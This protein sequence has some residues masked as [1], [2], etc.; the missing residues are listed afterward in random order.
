[1][2]KLK[3]AQR[4]RS[5]KA[6]LVVLAEGFM[7]QKEI[8]ER[9]YHTSDKAFVNTMDHALTGLGMKKQPKPYQNPK[10]YRKPAPPEFLD[11]V[12]KRIEEFGFKFKKLAVNSPSTKAVESEGMWGHTEYIIDL[13]MNHDT[14]EA[15]LYYGPATQN[16]DLENNTP[17]K[18][19][20]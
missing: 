16:I 11:K 19:F 7:G 4:L 13:I 8:N 18:L 14:M 15:D 1:M 2:I 17:G 5:I 6:G 3:A 12:Q 9:D 20:H 10:E